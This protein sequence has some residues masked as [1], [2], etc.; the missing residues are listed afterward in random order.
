[1]KKIFLILVVGLTVWCHP[2]L[3]Q[4][5]SSGGSNYA[6]Y[7]INSCDRE[8]YGVIVN[9][10]V[11]GANIDSQLQAMYASGQ[12]RLRI[13]IYFR[14]ETYG[15]GTVMPSLGGDLSSRFRSNLASFLNSVRQLGFVEVEL[16]FHPIGENDPS[17]WTVWSEDFYQENWNFI[18]NLRPVFVNSGLNYKIDLTNEA[19]PHDFQSILLQYA[20]R[21]WNDYTYTFGKADTIGFSVI[22]GELGRVQ[23]IPS[24]YQGNY[25]DGFDMHFY[26]NSYTSFVNAHNTLAS[27]GLTQSWVI[28]EAF[29]DDSQESQELRQAIQATGRNPLFLTQWPATRT[30]SCLNI[31]P[32]LTNTAYYNNVLNPID[33][34][35]FFV[36]QHYL[37]FYTRE[38]DAGGLAFWAG[39]IT[40]CGSDSTCVNEQRI[41]V[42]HAYFDSSE[43]V[44]L[45]PAFA[46]PGT[47]VY[48]QAFVRQCY[49]SYLRR[50]PDQRG[51]DY[52]LNNLEGRRINRPGN[53]PQDYDDMIGAF[54][55]SIEYRQRF[56]PP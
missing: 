21:L 9:Y 32:P 7:R 46:Y 6:W 12:R 33:D 51:Y 11:A 43:S 56:G 24:V 25:P 2:V 36:R 41:G 48:N 44:Q 4:Y 16:S 54:I 5:Q 52:W 20:R 40:T 29:Y 38:P 39:K 35:Q 10:D 15:S 28:G 8:P 14:R 37:D 53:I 47:T 30:S 31:A 50:E 3:A 27:F 19:I 1:M 22:A 13:P 45:N 34:A 55:F 23:Q 42:S 49:L 26:E 17:A 18:A